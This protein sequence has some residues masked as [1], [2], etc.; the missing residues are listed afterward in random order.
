MEVVGD[1]EVECVKEV[2]ADTQDI[3]SGHI[4]YTAPYV[5]SGGGPGGWG[6]A[7]VEVPYQMYRHYGDKSILEAYYGNMRRYIDYL[8]THSEFG[9]VTSDRKGEW[10]RSLIVRREV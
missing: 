1:A 7:I 6:S 8:E 4:Q 5:R 10:C 9:L 3:H 2:Y